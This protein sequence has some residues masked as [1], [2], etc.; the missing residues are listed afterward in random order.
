MSTC[1][2]PGAGA[3]ACVAAL[4][5]GNEGRVI[6]VDCTPAMITKARSNALACGFSN[7]EFHEADMTS[8]PVDDA[9]ADIVL[10]NGAINL[11]HDKRR[12]MAEAYRVLRTGGRIQIADMVRDPSAGET[13][14]CAGDESWAD[15]VS[16][17][18]EPNEFMALMEEVGFSN[19][20]LVAYTGYRTAQHTEG[21]LFY[22]EKTTGHAP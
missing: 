14:C 11:S 10:S 18:L 2:K 1:S 19:V 21:A 22:G 7:L 20:Q 6:G 17:T 12:V 5:V 3:D 15:C 4:L 16:G 8:L 9:L 13:A